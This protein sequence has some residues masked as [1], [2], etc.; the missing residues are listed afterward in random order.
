MVAES[1][2]LKKMVLQIIISNYFSEVMDYK[3]GFI[4]IISEVSQAKP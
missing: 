3:L 2:Y 1:V 4:I